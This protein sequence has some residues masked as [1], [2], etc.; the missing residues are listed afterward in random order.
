MEGRG[1][2]GQKTH[3]EL[4]TQQPLREYLN[5][6]LSAQMRDGYSRTQN[7]EDEHKL[8]EKNA[9]ALVVLPEIKGE[10]RVLRELLEAAEP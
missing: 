1:V 2:P 4:W 10:E 5:S 9:S 7:T 3:K 6:Q 8:V